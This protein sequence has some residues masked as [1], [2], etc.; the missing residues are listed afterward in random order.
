MNL[1]RL[2]L[3]FVTLSF[4]AQ[5]QDFTT[6]KT[7]N[8]KARKYYDAARQ[9]AREGAPD[10]A[11]RN[12]EKA[13]Q[14]DPKL[15]SA[16]V[17]IASIFYDGGKL[18][19]AAALYSDILKMAPDYDADVYY[20]LG[21]TEW[22]LD[23]F[24]PAAG[25]FQ[26][27]LQKEKNDQNRLAAAKRYYENSLFAAQAVKNPV[28]FH[29]EKM[30]DSINT[31]DSEYLPTLTA[32][33]EIFIFTRNIRLNE[34]FY[35]SKKIDGVW[36]K[37][38]PLK[39]INS[40]WNEGAQ[41]ISADGRFFVFTACNRQDGLGSCDLYFTESVNGEWTKPRNIGTP[42]NTRGWESQPALSADGNT[43]YFVSERGGGLGGRDIWLSRKQ[44]DGSWSNPENLGA[45]INTA[46]Y[47]QSPFLHPDGQ[48][49]YYM[50]KGL[51]G[52]G[53]YD[54]YLSRKQ[55]D[56]TWGTPQNLGFPINTK[57]HEGALFVSL[58]GKTAY[59]A[60]DRKDF[61]GA[62][63]EADESAFEKGS[64]EN[65][66]DIFQFELPE[67]VRPLPVTYVKANV[68]DSETL[69]PL[70]AQVEFTD[71]A[72]AKPVYTGSTDEAGNFLVC[73]PYGKNYALAVS[74]DNY[75]FHSENFALDSSA[76]FD[77]PFLLKIGLEK[78]IAESKKPEAGAPKTS[79]PVI[80]KNVFFETASA[81]LRPESVAEL[82]RLKKLLEAHPQMNIQI[83][84]H[85]DNVGSDADNQVLSTNRA[86]AV[87]D[88][89]IKNGIAPA[90]L[91]YKG[92][93]ESQPIDTN[94]TA[95]GRQNNRRT[96]FM[97]L[98]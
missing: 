80:L 55:A 25:H 5:A 4:A 82:T 9:N 14:E 61:T 23:K 29:P 8:E 92:F 57:A 79:R 7:T 21:V 43:L 68:F 49:L 64:S 72:N 63:A 47:E 16:K 35:V 66:T 12:F 87:Y 51:P 74:A 78:I 56:G 45:P 52:M 41:S 36:R 28:P 62:A 46:D 85:T 93:G 13:L 67:K 42:I 2:V 22:K 30:T 48:T 37:A 60:T 6:R 31:T 71:L 26:A 81:A 3:F 59:F 19:E 95:A 15:L 73:L 83:N 10:K 96:E 33:G 40:E 75:L 38:T 50:S 20:M 97:V 94:D 53:G 1:L 90:R 54:L 65:H 98:R 84:G 11:I 24:E 39:S 44:T 70:R 58:D 34:D 32:D 77:K 17:S 86:K 88:F 91:A 27:F 76:T 69:R 18:E 89:L